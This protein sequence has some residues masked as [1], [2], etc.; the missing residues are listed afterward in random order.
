MHLS[1]L[2]YFNFN[3]CL[4]LGWTFLDS[5]AHVRNIIQTWSP[6]FNN[7]RE[8]KMR[9]QHIVKRHVYIYI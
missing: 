4:W 2:F 8:K 9:K 3:F 1:V 7:G 6:R 5:P